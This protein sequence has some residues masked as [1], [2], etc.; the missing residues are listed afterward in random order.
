MTRGIAPRIKAALS[1]AHSWA[2][3]GTCDR[4][5]VGA[6]VLD[7]RWSPIT[8]SYNSSPSGQAHC[9]D[10]GHHMEHDHC[11]RTVHAEVGAVAL[12]A[13]RGVSLA[14]SFVVVTH[15]PCWSCS[16]LLYEAGVQR[17]YYQHAYGGDPHPLLEELK[18]TWGAFQQVSEAGEGCPEK[19]P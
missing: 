8:V 10:V 5:R 9:D 16:R 2:A 1:L 18:R 4:A 12:A 7:E 6:V 14:G 13:R 15:Q 11:V 17:V 3:L 19:L